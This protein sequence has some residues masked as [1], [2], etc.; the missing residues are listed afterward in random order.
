VPSLS[1]EPA[2]I[3]RS[4][5]NM[6]GT[7][8]TEPRLTTSPF[9]VKMKAPPS[10]RPSARPSA[11]VAQSNAAVDALMHGSMSPP[12]SPTSP[13]AARS[14]GGIDQFRGEKELMQSCYVG[15]NRKVSTWGLRGGGVTASDSVCVCL[16]G[17]R[18]SRFA[19]VHIKR[20]F[21]LG[22]HT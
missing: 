12:T 13:L 6:P 20:V 3:G 4:L 22:E 21:C 18:E 10:T 16:R 9:F 8:P 2:H 17:E 1:F 7:S 5:A 14:A 19:S 15:E 11:T